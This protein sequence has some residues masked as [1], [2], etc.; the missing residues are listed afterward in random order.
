[1]VRRKHKTKSPPFTQMIN[2]FM[3]EPAFQQLSAG[4]QMLYV[5]LKRFYNGEN[6]GQIYLSVRKAASLLNVSKNTASKYFGELE[7]AGFIVATEVG[8]LGIDGKGK[9][10]SWRLTELGYRGTP[11]S[12]DYKTATL[13]SG[14]MPKMSGFGA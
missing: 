9:A 13:N 7:R 12:R 6:N 8:R 4:P 10:T 3:D 14:A 11:A 2:A 1:M 5:H